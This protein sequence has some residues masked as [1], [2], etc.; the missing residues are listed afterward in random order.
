MAKIYK[1]IAQSAVEYS[2]VIAIVVSALVTIN[3]Y[4]KRGLQGRMRDASDDF[5]FTVRDMAWPSESGAAVFQ[6]QFETDMVTK[7]VTTNIGYDNETFKMNKGG[8]VDYATNSQVSQ[9]A[10]DLF[11]YDY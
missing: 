7:K 8:T 9:A 1:N 3:I 4:V 6:K 2:L 10:G 5:A 11:Q